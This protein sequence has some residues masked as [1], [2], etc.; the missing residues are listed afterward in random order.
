MT[1]T[2]FVVP[3]PI[4]YYSK[5]LWHKRK[6]HKSYLFSFMSTHW[7]KAMEA[8]NEKVAIYKPESRLAPGTESTGTFILDF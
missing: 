7:W 6:V 2:W 8:H 3:K 1:A 5:L 4:D